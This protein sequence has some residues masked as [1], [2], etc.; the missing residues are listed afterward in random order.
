MLLRPKISDFGLVR[1]TGEGDFGLSVDQT[2]TLMG[3]PL[4]MAPEAG[5]AILKHEKCLNSYLFFLFL[6]ENWLFR[7]Q[8]FSY[9]S[10]IKLIVYRMNRL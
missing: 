7:N 4:Y 9:Y 10:V 6:A 1:L 3:T 8:E 5:D 2:N